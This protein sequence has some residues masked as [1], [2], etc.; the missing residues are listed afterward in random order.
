VTVLSL[1][2]V[3]GI[4][5]AQGGLLDKAKELI[6]HM[7]SDSP[8]NAEPEQGLSP[9]E[10]GGG[11]KEAL[12]VGTE[13]VV[14]Q[15][16]A[17]DGFNGDPEIHIPLPSVLDD[18]ESV[19]RRLGMSSLLTDLELRLNRAAEAATPRAR[20]L[21]LQSISDMTLED[22]MGIY[23]GPDDAATRYFQ[24]KMSD[25]L[26]AEMRPVV[27]ESLAGTGAAQAYDS[28][29]DKYS[30]VPFA[31]RV[32]ADLTGYVVEKGMEGVFHYLAKEEAAIRQDP[33]KRTTELLQRVFGN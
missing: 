14:A 1:G 32:N 17:A 24:G 25:P 15:L 9:A 33:V 12:R 8:E 7:S 18:V 19:L 29:M 31:P 23:Q 11:L 21:F 6:G 2:L 22:V 28:V 10:I 4:A 13:T 3:S 27:E 30:G 16:G 26:A 5:S 20:E